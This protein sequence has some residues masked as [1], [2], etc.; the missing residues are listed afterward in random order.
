MLS[1]SE[2]PAGL[3]ADEG[4]DTGCWGSFLNDGELDH[5]IK[6]YF[7]LKNIGVNEGLISGSKNNRALNLLGKTTRRADDSWETGL[8]WKGDF[9]PMVDSRFTARNR[10]ASLER[11]L[12]RDPN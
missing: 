12:D 6:F 11:K 9:A 3:G 2:P 7:E 10:L 8:L 5:L 4:N 1:L